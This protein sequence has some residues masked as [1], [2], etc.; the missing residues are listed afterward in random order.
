MRGAPVRASYRWTSVAASGF[1]GSQ[2]RTSRADSPARDDLEPAARNASRPRPRRVLHVLVGSCLATLIV[3][4]GFAVGLRVSSSQA[5][6]SRPPSAAQSTDK[7][8]LAL[9]NAATSAPARETSSDSSY[10]RSSFAQLQ[11]ALGV[12]LGVTLMPVGSDGAPISLGDWASGPAWSTMKVPL[13]IAALRQGDS[14][15]TN[16]SINAAITHSDNDAADAI[17]RGL[18]PP[19]I[20]AE[21]ID[22]VLR[23]AGDPTQVQSKRSRPEYSA[24]GQTDWSL[25]NQT[26]F[27]AMEACDYRS[28]PVFDLMAQI[29]GNQQWGLG[30]IPGTRFKG[31]WGPSETGGYLV[32]Q[33]GV[34]DTNRGQVA[35]AIAVQSNSGTVTDGIAQLS[36]VA[37][38]LRD[39]SAELPAGHCPD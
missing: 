36:Q 26:R 6:T 10:L 11:A 12:R 31:G 1:G 8:A 32:R 17:W 13:V 33:L 24:F 35:A 22:E 19:D 2:V 34:I 18:G 5:R 37:N 14:T 21:K 39:H 20:A 30:T 25:G 38:W 23:E 29:V 7:S 15:S 27:L 3:A 28:A 16:E 4:G 9:P